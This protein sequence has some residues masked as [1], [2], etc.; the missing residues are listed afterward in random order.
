MEKQE[1]KRVKVLA[2][3]VVRY[4][5]KEKKIEIQKVK[6]SGPNG[7]IIKEDILNYL[8]KSPEPEETEQSSKQ[9]IQPTIH[10]ISE[11]EQI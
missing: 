11:I 9:R 6:G 1:K 2:S 10:Q 4:F 5:A 3:P 7:R 8:K